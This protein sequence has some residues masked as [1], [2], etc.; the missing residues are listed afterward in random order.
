[1]RASSP[2]M[3]CSSRPWS[4][5]SVSPCTPWRTLPPLSPSVP[6]TLPTVP[7]SRPSQVLALSSLPA[8]WSPAASNAHA[9]PPPQNSNTM[10]ESPQCPTFLR[11]TFVEW[12]AASLRHSFWA[13]VYSQQQR[14]QGKTPQAAVRA[15]AFKWIRLLFRCWQDRTP[16]DASTSLQALHHRGSSLLQQRAKA[17]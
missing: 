17:S 2:P 3:S 12:A 11:Q 8:S 1:M 7:S 4:A 15:L 13:R 16:Y 14:D 5:S 10:P 6:S 9:L